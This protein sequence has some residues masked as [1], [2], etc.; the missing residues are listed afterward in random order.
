M[1]W[2]LDFLSSK[3]T[4][5]GLY[6]HDL[7]I[8]MYVQTSCWCWLAKGGGYPEEKGHASRSSWAWQV[9]MGRRWLHIFNSCHPQDLS[10]SP[11]ILTL[12]GERRRPL[13]AAVPVIYRQ[14]PTWYWGFNLRRGTYQ[15]LRDRT[16][17]EYMLENF[18]LSNWVPVALDLPKLV[19]T[20][21]LGSIVNVG[22]CVHTRC[23]GQT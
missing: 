9:T 18:C 1:K 13:G 21:G 5:G 16:Q 7:S 19:T 15:K 8:H 22:V 23:I 20:F 3:P 4:S 10:A 11:G 14:H 2:C 6:I 12:L 17:H